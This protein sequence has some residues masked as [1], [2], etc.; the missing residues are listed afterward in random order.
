MSNERSPREVCSTT[1]GT[2]GLTPAPP[3][4]RLEHV[5]RHAVGLEPFDRLRDRR[6]HEDLGRPRAGG[7]PAV[8]AL[9]GRAPEQ[10]PP[11]DAR[12][13]ADVQVVHPGGELAA[14]V[15][16][17]LAERATA[18][19]ARGG[20]SSPRSARRRATDPRRARSRAV[21][22]RDAPDLPADRRPQRV[23]RP[24]PLDPADPHSSSASHARIASR[25]NRHSSPTLRPGSSLPLREL[26]HDLLVHLQQ[27]RQLRRRQDLELRRRPERVLPEPELGLRAGHRARDLPRPDGI[28]RVERARDELRDQLALRRARARSTARCELARPRRREFARRARVSSASR[29]RSRHRRYLDIKKISSAQARAPLGGGLGRYPPTARMCN[30]FVPIL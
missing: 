15:D 20:S 26:D 3:L 4:D 6:G 16:A 27:L 23:R 2:S 19:R 21:R 17:A 25:E 5:H 9:D 12:L 30:A 24:R 18:P 8:G 1:I 14:G 29:L 10:H 11:E 7:A 22:S 13:G 28:L